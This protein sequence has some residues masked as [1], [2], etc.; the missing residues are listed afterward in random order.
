[1]SSLDTSPINRMERRRLQTREHLK[2]AAYELL[3]EMGYARFTI[4]AVTERADVGYG[5]FL[6]HFEN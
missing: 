1:M 4:K 3:M 6:L 5:T 2:Q